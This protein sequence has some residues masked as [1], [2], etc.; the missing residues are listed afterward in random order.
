MTQPITMEVAR[1][2][3]KPSV[4][5]ELRLD[6]DQVQ[7]SEEEILADL[8]YPAR[9]DAPARTGGRPERVRRQAP[10]RVRARSTRRRTPKPVG[11]L[12]TYSRPTSH[13]VPAMSRW[14]HGLSSTNS[15]RNSAA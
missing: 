8:L 1:M 11:P 14:T 13:A 3:F 9:P 6:A 12:P 10:A 15:S 2:R 4:F 5:P 7:V